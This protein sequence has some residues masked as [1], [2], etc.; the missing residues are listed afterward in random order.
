MLTL[1]DY[2]RSGASH[3]VRIALHLKGLPFTR[4][5]IDLRT[6]AHKLA[7]YRALNPQGLTPA[8][9]L[10]NGATLTQ[11]G[12]IIEWLE[13]TFPDPP[14]L[15]S[16][17]VARAQ[18]RAI[19]AIVACDIHPLGNLRV[20]K[21]LQ[22]D[23]GR[24]AEQVAAFATRWIREGFDAMEALIAQGPGGPWSWGETPGLADIYAAS[25]IYAATARYG[26]DMSPYPRLRAI[27]AAAGAHPAFQAAHPMVQSDAAP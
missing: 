25:Q 10:E 19:A 18:V 20:L 26:F 21:Y 1:H 6:G 15:P 7:P 3:R 22:D 14:L 5:P 11:S 23:A 24:T 27:D 13:E 8:L 9:V 4:Q 16:D 12:A 2:F 17:P